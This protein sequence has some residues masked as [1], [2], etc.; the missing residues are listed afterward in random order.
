MVIIRIHRLENVSC[1]S[2]RYDEYGHFGDR[3]I[4]CVP[5]NELSR[6]PVIYMTNKEFF[7]R[8]NIFIPRSKLS[9]VSLIHMTGKDNFVKT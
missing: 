6:V 1:S 4:F 9:L 5:S 3:V 2:Y 8:G 7:I